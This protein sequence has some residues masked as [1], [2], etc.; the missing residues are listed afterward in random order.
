MISA[1]KKNIDPYFP[2]AGIVAIYKAFAAT[3][4]SCSRNSLHYRC[5]SIAK[6]TIS[7]RPAAYLC[8]MISA[9]DEQFMAYWS[10]H[11]AKERTSV[12][13]FLI[14]LSCGFAVGAAVM[15]TLM[16]GWYERANM[17]ANSKL[18]GPVFMLAI[19]VLSFFLAFFYRKFRWEM[20]EQRYLELCA[21]KNRNKQ[22][23]G[24]A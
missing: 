9:Q 19:L 11:G 23:N 10:E 21:K 12:R 16:S 5:I 20:N 22:E 6:T 7:F 8:T 4:Q 24:P 18:S 1:A 3:A 14:G 17:E 15:I 13:P 2:A